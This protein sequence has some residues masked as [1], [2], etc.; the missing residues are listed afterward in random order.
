MKYSSV[1]LRGKPYIINLMITAVLQQNATRNQSN[2][3]P[4][5]VCDMIARGINADYFLADAWFATKHILRM[6]IEHSLVAI[7]RMKKNKMTSLTNVD[8]SDVLKKIEDTVVDFFTQVM[9]MDNFTLRQEAL[10]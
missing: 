9:Q 8:K 10:E 6:T 5:M 4:E 1:R 7:V 3:P 2:K